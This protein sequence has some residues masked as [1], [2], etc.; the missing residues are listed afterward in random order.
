[1]TQIYFVCT[2]PQDRQWTLLDKLITVMR[3]ELDRRANSQHITASWIYLSVCNYL[4]SALL[5]AY[6]LKPSF[7]ITSSYFGRLN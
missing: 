4:P 5:Y 2:T 6:V 7:I 3:H 1:M